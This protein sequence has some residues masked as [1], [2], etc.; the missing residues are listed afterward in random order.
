MWMFTVIE[1]FL[2]NKRKYKL[3]KLNNKFMWY[4][5]ILNDQLSLFEAD[6]IETV[7]CEI[8]SSF[9]VRSFK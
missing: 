9:L 7:D 4:I 5:L 8:D 3:Y 6:V 1:Y 2:L